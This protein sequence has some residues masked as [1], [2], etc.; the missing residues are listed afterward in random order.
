MS[1][2]IITASLS[3]LILI[4][5]TSINS[6]D[7]SLKTWPKMNHISSSTSPPSLWILLSLSYHLPLSYPAIPLSNPVEPLHLV[8][9]VEPYYLSNLHPSFVEPISFDI[10]SASICLCTSPAPIWPIPNLVPFGNT[11]TMFVSCFGSL[12]PS[13]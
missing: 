6:S 2:I 8:K 5:H 9:V 1:C 3:G 11:K 10:P 4:H 7:T 13:S 12:I